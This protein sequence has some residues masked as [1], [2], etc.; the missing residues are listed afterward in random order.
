MSK[1]ENLLQY[2]H[3]NRKD[4]LEGS[5]YRVSCAAELVFSKVVVPRIPQ[6]TSSV[7]TECA[8]ILEG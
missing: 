8:E 2:N 1:L 7:N 6:H 4:S 5:L 3:K